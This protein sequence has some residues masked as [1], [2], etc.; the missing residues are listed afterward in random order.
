MTPITR[1]SK[2]RMPTVIV[3]C[4]TII[5][6]DK[7]GAVG[8]LLPMQFD[9]LLYK[10]NWLNTEITLS[11][12]TMTKPEIIILVLPSIRFSMFPFAV[13]WWRLTASLL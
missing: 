7:L 4:P 9:A 3:I 11:A 2:P 8:H 10:F 1:M 5:L 6:R 12:R 13:S